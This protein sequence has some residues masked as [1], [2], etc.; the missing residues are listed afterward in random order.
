MHCFVGPMFRGCFSASVIRS[1][2]M[3]LLLLLK[4][5]FPGM[6]KPR[7][8]ERMACVCLF[9][10]C[11]CCCPDN[12]RKVTCSFCCDL[13]RE[14]LLMVMVVWEHRE[15]NIDFVW[16]TDWLPTTSLSLSF[17]CAHRRT[18]P[19]VWDREGKKSAVCVCAVSLIRSPKAAD[20]LYA[21]LSLPLMIH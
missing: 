6:T 20:W 2:L 17:C 3:V 14:E 11:C 16:L 13:V 18:M 5:D 8:G 21:P 10:C 15:T 1:L 7:K 4:R 9:V 19:T 12:G